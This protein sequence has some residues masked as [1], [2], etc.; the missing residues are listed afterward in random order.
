MRRHAVNP[1]PQRPPEEREL[2]VREQCERDW[3]RLNEYYRAQKAQG[4][5]R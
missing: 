2:S 3:R 4:V 1:R 5:T